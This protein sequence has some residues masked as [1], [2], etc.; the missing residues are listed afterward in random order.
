MQFG[1][2]EIQACGENNYTI[3]TLGLLAFRPDLR[4]RFVEEAFDGCAPLSE[5]TNVR[6]QFFSRIGED[7]FR[8]A[9]E[10]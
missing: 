8:E 6:I 1:P 9:I 4:R 10:R 2:L 7:F 3:K 5:G